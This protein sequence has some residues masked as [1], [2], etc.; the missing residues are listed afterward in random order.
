MIDL[1]TKSDLHRLYTAIDASRDAMRPF[2]QNR[3]RMIREFVGSY[4]NNQ[5]APH[6]VLV[7]LLSMTAEVY[8]IGLAAQNPRCRVTTPFRDL[9]PFAHRW[10]KSLNDFIQAM[11]FCETL[12]QLVLD[13]IFT[14]GIAKVHQSEWKSVQLD[15]D[16]WADPGRP[17]ISRISPDD[18]GMDM[19]VKDRRRCKFM[20]DEYRVSWET[21]KNDPDYDKSVLKELSPTSKW[22]RGEEEANQITGGAIVDDDEYEPMIDLM[23]VWLPDLEQVAIFPRHRETKPL[24]VVEAGPTG[25]PYHHLS[26][27]DVPDN[28]IPTSPAHNLMGLHLLYNGLLRKQSRQANRQKTNPTY[29]PQ[30]VEDAERMKRV[31]DGEWVKVADP[32]GI[33]V[34]TQGGVDQANVAF[35]M[36]VMDLFDRQAGNLRA[37]AGLGAQTQTVGQEQLIHQAA[38][39]K[40]ARMQQRTHGF[41]AMLLKSLGHL[42]WA[43]EMLEV[44]SSDEVAPGTGVYVDTSW[45]PELREGAFWQ[46]NFDIEPYS[47]NYEPPEAKAMKMER[48]MAQLVQLYPMLQAAGG[49]IDV[50]ELVKHYAETMQLPE[51]ENVITF[52]MPPSQERP[53]P[54]QQLGKPAETT[55]NYV[56]H[57]V[58]TGGTPESRS[59]ILQQTLLG[60]GQ[61]NQDQRASLMRAG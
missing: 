9:W 45:T 57:N 48:A 22:D 8:T 16:V 51:L 60:G 11:R 31:K 33:N 18:F 58:P 15:D 30:S 55:R 7:N 10:Q 13:A 19:A 61:T 5:G 53:E 26:F 54:T 29:R 24:K 38:S 35:S 28:L 40:E 25:G 1:G 2:R 50:Q 14:Y 6:E 12:Q 4:Y 59:S 52:G 37:M 17:H 46:Y 36:A 49:E 34:V 3:T 47:M 20:W 42:M 56:R 41:V 21:V 44:P 43:D 39:R 27:M 32:S 23:D